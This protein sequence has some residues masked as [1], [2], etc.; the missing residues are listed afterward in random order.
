[1]I[2]QQSF[3]RYFTVRLGIFFVVFIALWIQVATWVYHF[4]WDDTTE[5]YLYQDLDLALSGQ[6]S[7]PVISDEKYIG[8]L[9]NMPV[10]F[11]HILST[12]DVEFEHTFLLPS[13]TGDMYILKSEGHSGE[14]LYVIHFFSHQNSPSLLPI[15]LI[16]S[17]FMLFPTGFL[18]WRIWR[19]ISLDINVLKYSLEKDNEHTIRFVELAEIQS[20]LKM[21]R[22]AQLHAQQQERLFS[23]FLSH[24]VRTPLTRVNNSISRLQQIDDIPLDALDVIDELEAGQRELAETADA[25]LLLCQPNK[26]KLEC[27]ALLPILSRWQKQW[28]QRGLEIELLG[29][30]Q[31]S[32]QTIQPKLFWLLLTQVAKNALQHGDGKLIVRCLKHGLEFENAR[33]CTRTNSGHGLGSKI[34]MQVSECFGWKAAVHSGDR[35]M[36]R[37]LW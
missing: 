24:E 17:G 36:L 30:E 7:M 8:I 16:L 25:V 26:A 21:A 15:F 10:E 4:A 33:D 18:A 35:Y 37:V 5:H 34:I 13:A 29:T 6:L 23:S 11:Q 9:A 1:M 27:K 32:E 20:S 12:H 2:K 14:P 3:A 19:S 22:F 31:I 28:A